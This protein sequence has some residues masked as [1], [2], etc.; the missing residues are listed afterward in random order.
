VEKVIPKCGVP[1][2]IV[3][4]SMADER[5]SISTKNQYN[6]TRFALSNDELA[7][8]TKGGSFVSLLSSEDFTAALFDVKPLSKSAKID[9]FYT[10]KR[11]ISFIFWNVI[12]L[13][14]VTYRLTLNLLLPLFI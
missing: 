6:P 11:T 10:L 4:S 13:L 12:V 9:I 2:M 14:G 3:V 1:R 7:Y 8:V 5:S